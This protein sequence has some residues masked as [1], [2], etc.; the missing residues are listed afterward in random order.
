MSFHLVRLLIAFSKDRW[1]S[2]F[3][4]WCDRRVDKEG[5]CSRSEQTSALAVLFLIN[6]ESPYTTDLDVY[7]GIFS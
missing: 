2:N 3:V 7:R 5:S 4:Q 1:C 6:I